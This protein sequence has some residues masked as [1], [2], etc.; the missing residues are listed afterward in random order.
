MRNYRTS[1]GQSL[2]RLYLTDYAA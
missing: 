1:D 2:I